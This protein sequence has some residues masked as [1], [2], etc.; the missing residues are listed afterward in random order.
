MKE[1]HWAIGTVGTKRALTENR[2]GA[3]ILA[4]PV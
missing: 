2:A 3:T 1:A 4:N